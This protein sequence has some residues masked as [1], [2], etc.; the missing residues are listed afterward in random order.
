MHRRR[1]LKSLVGLVALPLVP[2]AALRPRFVTGGIV[3]PGAYVVGS[4]RPM[5]MQYNLGPA[6]WSSGH[7][8]IY[9]NGR[10]VNIPITGRY[11]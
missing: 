5:W 6:K 9:R 7:C 1:F 3:R 4:S 11:A 8:V 2:L 10:M